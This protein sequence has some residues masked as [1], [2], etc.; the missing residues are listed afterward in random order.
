M[1]NTTWVFG[2][3]FAAG[4]MLLSVPVAAQ[5]NFPQGNFPQG[6]FPQGMGRPQGIPAAGAAAD[7][8]TNQTGAK[9]AQAAGRTN[10]SATRGKSALDAARYQLSNH[11]TD[12]IRT[13]I[14]GYAASEDLSDQS[15]VRAIMDD[16]EKNMPLVPSVPLERVDHQALNDQAKDMVDQIYGADNREFAAYI[17]KKAEEEFP[18]YKLG[19]KVIVKYNMGPKRFSVQGTLYRITDNSITVEDKIINF[20]DLNDETRSKFDPQKN[21]TMRA[22]FVDENISRVNRDKIEKIQENYDKLK[23]EITKR[24]ETVGYICDPQTEQW[25]TAQE[26][27]K[28]YIDRLVRDKA[29]QR[30]KQQ[31]AT[32][33][34]NT[35]IGDNAEQET[36]TIADAG[37]TD[38]DPTQNSLSTTNESI[39]LEDNEESR[40]K[41][42]S[43][44]AKAEEQKKLANENFTGIDTDSGYK[45]ACWGFTISDARYALWHEPEFPYIRP[46]LGRD[47]IA[48]PDEGLDIGIAGEPETIELVYIS[49]S[50]SKVVFL[51]KD[52][53]RTDFLKFKDSLTE[54][55]GRAAE[56]KGVSSAAFTNI[57]SGKTKPQQIVDSAEID[58][59]KTEVKEAQ[60]AFNQALADLKNATDDDRDELQEKRDKAA[61]ALKAA[62]AKAESFENAVSSDNLPYIYTRIKLAKDSEGKTVLPFAFNWKGSNVSGTLIFYYD[63]TRDKVTDLVFVKEY[64]K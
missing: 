3:M 28:N 54:Q 38:A 21:K 2:S 57:F 47:V 50:L 45:N 44:I 22:R 49:N 33:S 48:F 62:N 60:A 55:Y 6:N 30:P 43:V 16:I 24:N 9:S 39:K 51:M 27:A 59:A 56:D 12:L 40:E 14:D 8:K 31:T 1:K 34:D 46:E 20:V 25:S 32:K 4:C 58:A 61:Q 29:K 53:S 52:C 15:V 19:D 35:I 13:T 23:N 7:S 18:L 26:I 42:N 10:T 41:Y 17:T 11:R 64:K 63:K 37:K 36:S 5:G